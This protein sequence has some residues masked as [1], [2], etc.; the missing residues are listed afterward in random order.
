MINFSLLYYIYS[1]MCISMREIQ[2]YI[3]NFHIPC[4]SKV[5]PWWLVWLG[6]I[7][8]TIPT[9]R[10]IFLYSVKRSSQN[11]TSKTSSYSDAKWIWIVVGI[12]TVRRKRMCDAEIQPRSQQNP[13]HYNQPRVLP[14]GIRWAHPSLSCWPAITWKGEER[15]SRELI[16]DLRQHQTCNVFPPCAD[17]LH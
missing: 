16:T 10:R 11:A 7:D 9:T 15:E 5:M 14:C 13:I 6:A 12:H 2:N 3:Q 1:N 8:S 4:R 17:D